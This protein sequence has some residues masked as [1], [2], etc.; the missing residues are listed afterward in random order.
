MKNLVPILIVCICVLFAA[1]EKKHPTKT[2]STGTSELL[3]NN[4]IYCNALSGGYTSY[5]SYVQPAASQYANYCG[6]L[7]ASCI[8]GNLPEY[9]ADRYFHST[10]LHPHYLDPPTN[11]ILDTLRGVSSLDLNAWLMDTFPPAST[12]SV[13]DIC[14]LIGMLNETSAYLILASS[15][16]SHIWAIL[17][18][19]YTEDYNAVTF[20]DTSDASGWLHYRS[21]MLPDELIALLN[22]Y[23]GSSSSIVVLGY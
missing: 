8:K 11:T 21:T 18:V 15:S 3:G 1:V 5:N 4:E 23:T 6:F 9:W 7:T 20:F 2:T 17:N 16:S 19:D 13:T 12:L 10:Y 22:S 14:S